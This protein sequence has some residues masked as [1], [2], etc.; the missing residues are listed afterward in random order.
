MMPFICHAQNSIDTDSGLM[1]TRG[2]GEKEIG[3]DY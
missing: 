1:V 2:W 3:S